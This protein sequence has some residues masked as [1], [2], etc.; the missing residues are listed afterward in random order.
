MIMWCTNQVQKKHMYISEKS[1]FNHFS[2]K[3]RYKG[4]SAKFEFMI[5]LGLIGSRV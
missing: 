3:A 1:I 5:F 4:F 2:D